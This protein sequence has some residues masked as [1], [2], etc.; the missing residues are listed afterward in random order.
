MEAKSALAYLPIGSVVITLLSIFYVSGYLSFS[1]FYWLTSLSIGDYISICAPA[2]PALL[3]GFLASAVLYNSRETNAAQAEEFANSL[4]AARAEGA[5]LP[6]RF[7]FQKRTWWKELL[8]FVLVIFFSFGY[9]AFRQTVRP[10][11]AWQSVGMAIGT[12]VILFTIFQAFSL[13]RNFMLGIFAIGMFGVLSL[14][15]AFGQT[16]GAR[17]FTQ[18]PSSRLELSDGRS[19]CVSV[20]AMTRQG[21]LVVINGETT[22]L[23][24]WSDVRMIATELPCAARGDS[25]NA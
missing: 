20:L 1:G 8:A 15:F 16:A 22:V 13:W 19:V 25:A 18:P 5:P 21:P 17:R 2:L 10:S 11:E 9:D 24:V 12:T 23:H 6:P 4:K 14:T 7:Y 3:F